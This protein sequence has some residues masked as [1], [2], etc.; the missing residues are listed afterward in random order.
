MESN[1]ISLKDKTGKKKDYRVLFNI[2][3]SESKTNYVI[4]TDDKMNMYGQINAFISS[5]ELSD[6]GNMTK[7]KR[8]TNQNDIE[9]ITKILN[10]L[11]K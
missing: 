3:S 4:Y 5:Y 2:E 7:L 8:I 6:K 11:Q 1:Y 9:F 10:S